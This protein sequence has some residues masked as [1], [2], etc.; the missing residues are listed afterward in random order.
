MRT[1]KPYDHRHSD[2]L[3]EYI[4]N[5]EKQGYKLYGTEVIYNKPRGHGFIDAVLFRIIPGTTSTEWLVAE[6]K[7]TIDNVGEAIR[8]VKSAKEY[9]FQHHK[10]L[11]KTHNIKSIKYPLVIWADQQNLDQCL[12]YAV[13]FKEMDLEFFHSNETISNEILNKFEISMAVFEISSGIVKC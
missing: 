10:H 2:M 3:K 11:L 8:Q 9:F 6:I 4:F 12:E 5:K 1:Q 13:L 7:P